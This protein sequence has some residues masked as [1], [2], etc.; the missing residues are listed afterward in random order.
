MT[1]LER[2]YSEMNDAI[3]GEVKSL[4]EGREVA[5]KSKTMKYSNVRTHKVDESKQ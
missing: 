3:R 5:G 4:F 1:K 2:G